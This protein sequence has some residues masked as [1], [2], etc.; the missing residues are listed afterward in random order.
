MGQ[1]HE[2]LAV[3]TDVKG[4]CQK[5]LDETL[6]TFSSKK[7]HFQGSIKKYEP[8]TADDK[9]RP[10]N[11]IKPI[12]TTVMEKLKYALP[13]F[14]RCLDVILQKESTSCIAKADLIVEDSSG[15]VVTMAKDIPVIVLVQFENQLVKL[16]NVFD[17]IPTADPSYKWTK[18]DQNA[19]TYIATPP[20]RVRTKKVAKPILLH[21]AT[22]QHPAQVQLIN[23]D[24]PVGKWMHELSTG[25]MMPIEKS[26][27]LGRLDTLIESVKKARAKANQTTVVNAKIGKEIEKYLLG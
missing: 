19:N 5:I 16:R 17:A 11:E 27:I 20:E 12:V 7:E 15:A 13:S 4:K 9:D 22:P 6:N 8:F 25:A 23:D 10:E 14:S 3:E 18:D 21:E 24:I 2:L 1:L 26:A